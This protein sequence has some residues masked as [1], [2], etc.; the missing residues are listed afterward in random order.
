[1]CVLVVLFM[2]MLVFAQFKA[3]ADGVKSVDEKDYY[4]AELPN[5]SALQLYD[6]VN[7]WVMKTFKN[8]NI[9]SSK[10]AGKLLSLHAVFPNAF[11]VAKRLWVVDY[12]DVDLNL[13]IYFKDGKIRFDAPQINSMKVHPRENCSVVFSGGTNIMGSGEINMYK[14]DGNENKPNIISAFNDFINGLVGN[15]VKQAKSSDN[16]NW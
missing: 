5:Q 15:I 12:A 3:T 10:E 13:M 11:I 7:A 14:K 1:M 16:T 9:V 8:P 4:V 2:P 6:A